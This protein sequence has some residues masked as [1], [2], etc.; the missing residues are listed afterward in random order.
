VGGYFA[1]PADQAEVPRAAVL[2]TELHNKWLKVD[3]HP[4]VFAESAAVLWLL[5]WVTRTS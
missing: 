2:K 3:R 1:L 5:A 4:F